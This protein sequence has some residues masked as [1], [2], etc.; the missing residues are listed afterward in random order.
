MFQQ[1]ATA[2]SAHTWVILSMLL[3]VTFFLGVVFLVLT[4]SKRDNQQ[5]AQLPLQDLEPLNQ[6]NRDQRQGG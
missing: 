2:T 5:R 6:R 4:S 3:F 1:V